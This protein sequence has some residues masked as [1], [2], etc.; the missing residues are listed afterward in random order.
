MWWVH[1]SQCS[2]RTVP[3]CAQQ[4]AAVSTEFRRGDTVRGFGKPTSPR[5]FAFAAA[6]TVSF[7]VSQA[8]RHFPRV[9]S[10][11]SFFLGGAYTVGHK[12]DFKLKEMGVRAGDTGTGRVY[13]LGNSISLGIAGGAADVLR[14][15]E[16]MSFCFLIRLR[17]PRS[18]VSSPVC[19]SHL[20]FISRMTER[21]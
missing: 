16:M 5:D 2:I 19:F 1:H 10:S 3:G 18:G 9:Q 11:A 7:I 17:W 8:Q 15:S 13:G 20:S 12:D 6:S 21:E 14:R 4:L